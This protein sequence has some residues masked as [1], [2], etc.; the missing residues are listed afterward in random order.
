MALILMLGALIGSLLGL[1]G[2]PGAMELAQ[3]LA[4]HILYSAFHLLIWSVLSLVV[5]WGMLRGWSRR[6]N[7]YNVTHLATLL[8]AL[9]VPGEW[10]RRIVTFLTQIPAEV[11][12]V[13]IGVEFSRVSALIGYGVYV[14][15]VWV[16]ARILRGREAAVLGDVPPM[17]RT[18]REG[19]LEETLLTTARLVVFLFRL[20]GSILPFVTLVGSAAIAWYCEDTLWGWWFRYVVRPL[21]APMGLW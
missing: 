7:R 8:F 5:A 13:R 20:S 19:S 1:W 18:G 10:V 12:G 16:V 21:L 4:V 6:I 2:S 9:S 11:F 14:V 17:P 3:Y 15:L